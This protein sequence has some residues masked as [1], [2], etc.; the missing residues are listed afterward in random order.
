MHRCSFLFLQKSFCYASLFKLQLLEKAWSS[1][2]VIQVIQNLIFY[3]WSLHIFVPSVFK[4][5]F[6]EKNL[7]IHFHYVLTF[8]L[9]TGAK[10]TFFIVCI[11]NKLFKVK[12]FFKFGVFPN[13]LLYFLKMCLLTVIIKISN[14]ISEIINNTHFPSSCW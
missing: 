12:N 5:V 2:A 11:M 14:C 8:I 10:C 13:N 3:F 7:R 9:R 1:Y 6:Q 4:Y